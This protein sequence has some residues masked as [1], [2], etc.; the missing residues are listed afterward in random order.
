MLCK[1]RMSLAWTAAVPPGYWLLRDHRGNLLSLLLTTLYFYV[2]H[3]LKE[4][5]YLR[6]ISWLCRPEHS[7]TL[8]ESVHAQLQDESEECAVSRSSGECQMVASGEIWLKIHLW[9]HLT[10]V[11][12][13]TIFEWLDK[14]KIPPPPPFRWTLRIKLLKEPAESRFM[15]TLVIR[16][17]QEVM[18]MNK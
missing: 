4:E 13:R 8:R 9:E 7:L 5:I 18:N 3:D 6:D 16:F 1:H 14:C 15:S 17:P 10:E 2:K 11:L 12:G